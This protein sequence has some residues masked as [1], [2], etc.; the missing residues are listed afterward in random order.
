MT[1]FGIAEMMC[2]NGLFKP[3]INEVD[4]AITPQN[5]VAWLHLSNRNPDS[6][7]S[8]CPCY[9][10]P[11]TSLWN[12]SKS[13]LLENVMNEPSTPSSLIGL[14]DPVTHIEP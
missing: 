14:P 6:I 5:D 10:I 2:L 9:S 11:C 8:A 7:Y 12:P 4:V 1:E 13:T 3:R